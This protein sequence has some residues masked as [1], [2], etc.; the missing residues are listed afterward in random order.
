MKDTR[1]PQLIQLLNNVEQLFWYV[2]EQGELARKN[3]DREKPIADTDETERK[4][5]EEL[6]AMGRLLMKRYFDQVGL[7][8]LGYRVKVGDVEYHRGHREREVEILT[9]FGEVLYTLSVYYCGDGKSMRPFEAMANLPERKST[10]FAQELM[11]WLGIEQTYDRSQSFYEQFFKHSLSPRTIRET[12]VEM[13]EHDSEYQVEKRLPDKD[14]E[15]TIGV[16]SFDGKG[17]KVM[18]KERTTGKTREA[19]LGC[20][21]TVGEQERDPENLAKALVMPELLNEEESQGLTRNERAD[22]IRYFG[23]VAEPKETVFNDVEEASAERFEAAGIDTVVCLMDG[24]HTLWRQAK[25]H[26]P[27]AI[28]ILDVIHV[29][30]Y[31]WDAARILEKGKKKRKKLVLE[32]LTKIFQGNVG[33]VVRGINVRLAK[34][35]F[36]KKRRETLKSVVTYFNNH[37]DYMH[38]DLYLSSGL[39]IATGVIESAC[40]HL[41]QDRMDKS[42]AQWAITGAEAVLKLRCIRGSN[43]WHFYQDLRKQKERNKLYSGIINLLELA[44]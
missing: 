28:Y 4:V 10:Y 15:G 21:Y 22:Q 23:S 7:G 6:L 36:S 2:S 19:L 38:Y 41:I 5:H 33:F 27:D 18:P 11:A 25:E 34:N 43:D 42:G 1:P 29:L 32:W 39:P 3:L 31:L 17:I 30:D 14:S 37:R 40:G 9:V 24:A 26:F 16:V 20:I 44:A 35:K 13:S 12:V 8:D